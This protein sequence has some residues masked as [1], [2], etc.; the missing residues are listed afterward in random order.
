MFLLPSKF[1]EN[2]LNHAQVIAIFLK[3][4][5]RRRLIKKNTKNIRRTL[6]ALISVMAKQIRL[7]VR[8]ECVLPRWT[9]HNKNG[10]VP[11]WHY[12]VTDA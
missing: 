5:K 7:E 1:K 6:K 4:A 10:V 12:R 11:F 2:Q 8:M 9:F 3:C